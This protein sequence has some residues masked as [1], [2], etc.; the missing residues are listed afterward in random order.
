MEQATD[1]Q[2]SV[3]DIHLAASSCLTI[4]FPPALMILTRAENDAIIP[5][6]RSLSLRKHVFFCVDD[7]IP[8]VHE[9]A[10]FKY[11]HADRHSNDPM[12]CTMDAD[13]G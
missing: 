12:D 2:D 5:S 10:H 7:S 6:F 13:K 8:R 9:R 4:S 3:A 11:A 1:R